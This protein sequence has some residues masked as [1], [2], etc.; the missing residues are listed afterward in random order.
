M[1]G[2]ESIHLS[3]RVHGRVQGVGFRYQTRSQAHRLGLSGYVKNRF[4]G[5]VEVEAE[6]PRDRI[7]HFKR[8]LE[9]GPPGARVTRL[10]ASESAARGIYGGFTVEF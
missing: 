4:D 9:K 10:D 2:E 3:A 7:D 1:A 6:G 5:T 8:W